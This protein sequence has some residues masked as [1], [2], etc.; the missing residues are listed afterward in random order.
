VRGSLDDISL[1]LSEA[2]ANAVIHGN[3]ED[4]NKKVDICALCESPDQFRLVITDEGQGFQPDTVADP[5]M[6]ENLLS[7]HGRGLFLI[8][9]LMDEMEFR[10]GGRQIV[11]LKR[12]SEQS[13]SGPAR[14]VA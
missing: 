13:K 1:A 7:N 11:L 8:R 9:Q 14:T 12:C 5:T 2:L 6:R 3:R 10:L 4:P